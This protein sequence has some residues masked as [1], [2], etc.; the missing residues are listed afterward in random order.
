MHRKLMFVVTL[1]I[2]LSL[3]STAFAAEPQSTEQTI[4]SYGGEWQLGEVVEDIGLAFNPVTNVI[5]PY[6]NV[7][8]WMYRPDTDP[9][10]PRFPA[11]WNPADFVRPY[12]ESPLRRQ[13]MSVSDAFGFYFFRFQLPR[14]EAWFPCSWPCKWQCNYFNPVLGWDFHSPKTLWFRYPD[15]RFTDPPKPYWPEPFEVLS[16]YPLFWPWDLDWVDPFQGLIN[17]YGPPPFY[18]HYDYPIGQVATP[19]DT[20]H[21]A[22]IWFT[23]E[24][25]WAMNIVEV[26]IEGFIWQPTDTTVDD[27]L[28]EWPYIC[29]GPYDFPD[30]DNVPIWAP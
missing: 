23:N 6:E 21:P 9:F 18:E 17:P 22:E 11:Q 16:Q 3:A 14:D 13:D 19:F 7:D 4:V 26:Q 24:G 28:A 15:Y 8:V 5:L 2:L 25:G 20:V 1:A 27:Y 10:V 12:F 30:Y 29:G